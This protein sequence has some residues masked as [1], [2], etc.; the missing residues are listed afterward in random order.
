MFPQLPFQLFVSRK[1]LTH[2][3][4]DCCLI[5]YSS[6]LT[7]SVLVPHPGQ[8]QSGNVTLAPDAENESASLLTCA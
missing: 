5:H 7:T 6:S 1:T 4:L 2:Q 8:K 3:A